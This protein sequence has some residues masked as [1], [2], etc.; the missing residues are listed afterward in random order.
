MSFVEAERSPSSSGSP[1]RGDA[2]AQR[3]RFVAEL[4]QFV[5]FPS[6]SAQTHHAEDV[7]RCA[8]WLASHLRR[9][10]LDE[11][12]VEETARHPI[13]RAAW[14]GAAGAPTLLIYGH[15][16]VQPPDPV[17]EWRTPPFEPSVRGPYL[18]GR[19]ASDDKGQLFAHVKA[20]EGLLRTT[21]RLPINVICLF[22]GEEE[23]GSPNLRAYLERHA[24]EL[25]AD[26]AVISDTRMLGPDRP[27]LTY[28]LRGSL[29]LE[30]EVRGPKKDLHSGNFGGAVHNPLQALTELLATL[31]DR[32]GRITIPGFYDA[33]RALSTQ[34]RSYLAATG[35]S[36]A[37]L[38]VD[39]RA[40]RGWGESG[41][42]FY[43]RTTARP[44]LAITGLVGGY[45][46]EGVKG[47]IP[48]RAAAKL[49][50]RLVPDQNPEEIERLVRR[51]LQAITPPTVEM[52]LRSWPGAL[53]A[54][55]DRRHPILRAAAW[56][57]RRGFGAAPVFVRSGGSIPVVNLF[58]EVLCLPTALLGF[59]LASDRLHA[60]NE[61][62][63]LGRFERAI[64]TCQAFYREFAAL[65]QAERGPLAS[66]IPRREEARA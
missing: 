41:F 46:G 2:R 22:E 65:G 17:R 31:H 61:R 15:Y 9:I 26:G 59:A 48:A 64:A 54:L 39:A 47:V 13:V 6:V 51:H 28:A 32:N 43:E 36:D 21:G 60:P 10:G 66:Q 53:P 5:R 34:E 8:Q 4:Q 29:N 50:L 11:T 55:I 20:L 58:Q 40:E 33:V 1:P 23:I 30:I 25:V 44:S 57:Y 27:A 19:G 42:T 49:N 52:R 56:A 37:Q 14:R 12:R 3:A 62:F 24:A 63:H 45:Q 7:R 35:P 38:L 18:Y 16:D